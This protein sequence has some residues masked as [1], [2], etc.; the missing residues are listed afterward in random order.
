MHKLSHK[1][2]Q[3]DF[4]YPQLTR[5]LGAPKTNGKKTNKS[6]IK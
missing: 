4:S 2:L 3:Q 1:L 6:T 5:M